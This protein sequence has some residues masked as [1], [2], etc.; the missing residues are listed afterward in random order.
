MYVPLVALHVSLVIRLVGDA[1]GSV[2]AW[3]WGGVLN[4]ASI[5]AFLAVAVVCALRARR[6]GG[7]AARRPRTLPNKRVPA[8]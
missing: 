6:A 4:E 8:R 2:G 1:T 3:R 7:V 5:V